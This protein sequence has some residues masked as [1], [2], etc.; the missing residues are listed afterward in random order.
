MNDPTQPTYSI[1]WR[2]R[3]TTTD[4]AFVSVPVTGDLMI[5]QP[6]GTGRID[7]PRMVERAIEMS[8][9]E[10]VVWHPEGQQIEP[11]PIQTPPGPAGPVPEA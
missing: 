7:V 10:G 3:R 5:E 1:S 11:H 2:L 6:D 9:A 4:Y 8:R